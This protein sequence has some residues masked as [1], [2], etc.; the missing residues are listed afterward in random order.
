MKI[1]YDFINIQKL[2]FISSNTSYQKELIY[3]FNEDMLNYKHYTNIIPFKY[4]HPNVVSLLD[5][6]RNKYKS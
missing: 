5:W 3:S 4:P 6:K 2:G 1:G